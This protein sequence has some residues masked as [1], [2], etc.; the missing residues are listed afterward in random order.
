[1]SDFTK[2]R[3]VGAALFHAGRRTGGQ[4]NMTKLK[5]ASQYLRMSL[6]VSDYVSSIS[7]TAVCCCIKASFLFGVGGVGAILGNQSR[8]I[9]WEVM[10]YEFLV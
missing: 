1:M 8:F 6:T 5:V 3:P 10:R 7:D 4:R 9:T 2:M